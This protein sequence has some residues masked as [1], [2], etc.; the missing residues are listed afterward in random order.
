MVCGG[1]IHLLPAGHLDGEEHERHELE[2][3]IDHGSHVDVLV[4]FVGCFTAEQ[5]VVSWAS[6]PERRTHL[7]GRR[8][9]RVAARL[10]FDIIGG[11]LPG[12]SPPRPERRA[13]AVEP[14]PGFPSARALPGP[15]GA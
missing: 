15:P 8:F 4:T 5:H 2:D 14:A 7:S 12:A 10:R 9:S 13:V 3:D 1:N 6:G 11:W